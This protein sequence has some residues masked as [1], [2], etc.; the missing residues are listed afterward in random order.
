MTDHERGW[1]DI[2]KASQNENPKALAHPRK[3][4]IEGKTY[5]PDVEYEAD[6]SFL[7]WAIRE[8]FMEYNPYY[9]RRL[10][11]S[12]RRWVIPGDYEIM[13]NLLEA[14]SQTDA[15]TTD[16]L[17]SFVNEAIPSVI[18]HITELRIKQKFDQDK[19]IGI[20]HD[21]AVRNYD[22]VESNLKHILAPG[23]EIMDITRNPSPKIS[24]ILTP[25]TRN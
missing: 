13:F 12:I 11:A 5:I 24:G 7:L 20:G 3:L 2:E 19:P 10:L 25:K 6:G 17:R 18:G 23:Y 16:V 8:D 15:P 14:G 9:D 21:S 1:F 22:I 4:A